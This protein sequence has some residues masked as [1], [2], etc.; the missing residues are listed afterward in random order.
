MLPTFGP[1]TAHFINWLL[2]T[3]HG[4]R[5]QDMAAM[6]ATANP[7]RM[8]STGLP[9][10]TNVSSDLLGSPENMSEEERRRSQAEYEQWLENPPE[11]E[12]AAALEELFMEMFNSAFPRWDEGGYEEFRAAECFAPWEPEESLF[13]PLL[14]DACRAVCF[15]SAALYLLDRVDND[16]GPAAEEG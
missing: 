1:E 6:L 16:T 12:L 4:Q 10:G 15:H 2:N 9:E 3:R 14:T 8:R 5:M 7:L 11:D 13:R